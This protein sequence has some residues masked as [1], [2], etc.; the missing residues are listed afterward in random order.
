MKVFDVKVYE[1][2]DVIFR[3]AVCGTRKEMHAA[4]AAVAKKQ[5]GVNDA[6]PGTMG[7][8]RPMPGIASKNIPGIGYSNI[9]GTMFLNLADLTDE[10]IVHECAHAAFTR[11]FNI[12]SYTGPFDDDGFD[13]QEE[14]CYFIG[15]AAA[16]V[17]EIIKQNFK[18]ARGKI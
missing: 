7:M 17:R 11:E 14:Y 3:L 18:T 12:R 1:R 4:I 9:F 16:K 10:V 8:F 5:G 13:E 15:K 6:T 2:Y